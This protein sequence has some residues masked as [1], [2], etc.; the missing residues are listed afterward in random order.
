[1]G[2]PPEDMFAFDEQEADTPFPK[3]VLDDADGNDGAQS[4][5]SSLSEVSLPVD[6]TPLE[7]AKA[8]AL[9]LGINKA[10]TSTP[11][12]QSSQ[13]PP[14]VTSDGKIDTK[15]ALLRAK[16]I[17]MQMSGGAAAGGGGEQ[18]EMHHMDELEI[19]DYPPQVSNAFTFS[20]YPDLVLVLV[21]SVILLLARD[22]CVYLLCPYS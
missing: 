3:V 12:I 15:A 8:L 4:A 10:S 17:A 22:V 1:M 6:M 20:I 11:S 9:S 18:A 7:R 14:P 21:Y 2:E 13:P 5:A 19:N 16:M